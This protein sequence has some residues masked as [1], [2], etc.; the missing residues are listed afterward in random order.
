MQALPPHGG[1]VLAANGT[2]GE[3]SI[4]TKQINIILL[5]FFFLLTA[6]N[7]NDANAQTRT[8]VRLVLQITIDGLRADLLNRY[9]NGFGKGGFR[10]LMKKGTW[11]TNAHYQH[12][13]TETI[14]GFIPWMWP[15]P[16]PPFWEWHRP[17]Q[18]RDCRLW[19]CRNN[20]LTGP[21]LLWLYSETGRSITLLLI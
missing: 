5:I 6:G 4:M 13:N 21:L 19:K 14:V 15:Q 9:E 16:S 18:P 11:Y 12:A 10:F 2:H 3:R 8:E 20:R 1:R 17:V 7:H